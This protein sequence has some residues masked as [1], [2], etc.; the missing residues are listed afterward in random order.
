MDRRILRSL[1]PPFLSTTKRLTVSKC[2]HSRPAEVEKCPVFRILSL[3]N[4]LHTLILTKCHNLPFIL[5]LN[6]KRN[7]S[8]LVLCPNLEEI[9]L[10]IKSRDQ[11]HIKYLISMAKNRASRRT[12]FTSITIVGLGKLVPGMSFT[13]AL[14]V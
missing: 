10:Y 8:R 3:T 14:G 9:V 7:S 5:A 11:F 6:P 2:G 4:N 12:R 13:L 1:D